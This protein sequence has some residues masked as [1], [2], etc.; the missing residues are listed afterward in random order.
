MK[1]NTIFIRDMATEDGYA[2]T[3]KRSK[4]HKTCRG[5]GEGSLRLRGGIYYAKWTINGKTYCRSTKTG[6][7]REALAKLGEFVE[8][9]RVKGEERILENIATRLQ[10]VKAEIARVEEQKPALRVFDA[11]DA[12]ERSPNR[13][14]SGDRTLQGY[15]GQFIVFERWLIDKH[16][17]IKELRHVTQAIADEFISYIGA[18]RSANTF[19]KY[20]TFFACMW[21]V[22]AVAARLTI[23]PW[24]NI[25]RKVESN[26]TRRELTVEELQR[27]IA[28]ADG[29]MK[30][31]FAIGIY[32]G[33]RLGDCAGLEWGNVDMVKGIISV[34]PHKT[35]RHAHGKPAVIP[36]NP[37]LFKILSVYDN[38]VGYILPE[39]AALYNRQPCAVTYRIQKHF[40][41]CGIKTTSD[42][43]A[44][45][46]RHVDVGFHSLR[47]T[48]VSLSANAG[49][50]LAFVQA[51]VGHSNPAM[52][53]HYYHNDENAL[54]TATAAI[55]NVID[56]D[57][58]SADIDEPKALPL[59]ESSRIN[60]FKALVSD[61]SKGELL[62]ALEYLKTVAA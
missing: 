3:A 25:R 12:Y 23:N 48:F 13:P 53:R 5:K 10:G 31:L 55:P 8:P 41:A 58:S 44:G 35:A 56:V 59:A 60:Q 33:L 14:D 42:A 54:R 22:L 43:G 51:I 29:E 20:K 9:F 2:S 40:A 15:A 61:M 36:I 49:T 16:P 28:S 11:W 47:H 4:G 38:R 26:H 6:N 52:T 46:R 7:K 32:T 17:E 62:E 27:V 39:M 50:P 57:G 37:A 45:R 30:V 34:V 18:G 24:K 21:E 1:D 19:N